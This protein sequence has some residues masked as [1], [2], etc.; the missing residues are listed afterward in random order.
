MKDGSVGK[1]T[2]TIAVFLFK[3]LQLIT[4]LLYW[5]LEGGD[6]E[7]REVILS[8]WF[9]LQRILSSIILSSYYV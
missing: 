3:T 8:V 4:E 9:F 7:D 6:S 1:M 5:L 2:L